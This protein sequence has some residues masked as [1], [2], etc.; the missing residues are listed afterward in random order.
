MKQSEIK[1]FDSEEKF[2]TMA[3]FS[4]DWEKWLLPDGSYEYISPSCERITGY[5]PEEFATDPDLLLKITHP[6][7]RQM[8]TEHQSQHLCSE[9]EKAELE[10]RIISKSGQVRWI[11]HK[12]SSV[13]KQDGT[14]IGRRISNR[15]ITDKHEAEIIL[16]RERN[17]FLHGPVVTFTWQNSENWPVE[18]V[19][20]NVFGVL[21]YSTKEF[22]EGSILYASLI[23]PDDLDRV[24]SEVTIHSNDNS[25]SFV[26]EPYRLVTCSGNTIWVIDTTTIIKDDQGNITHYIGYLV[27]I[28]EQKRQEQIV[29]KSAMQQEQLKRF[30]SLKTMAGAIAHRFNN[31]MM[32]VQ[33]NLD[34]MTYTLL[35]DSDEYKMASNAAEA[36]KGASQ[37]GSMMLS[38]VGQR[39]LQLREISLFNLVRECGTAIKSLSHSSISL[40]IIPPA[41]EL[42]CSMDQ[43]QIQEVIENILTN[44]L[45]SMENITGTIVIS[46]GTEYCTTDSFPIA[47]QAEDTK[48][49]MYAFCQIKDTGQGINPKNLPRI[50]EPFYTT[51]FVGR[52]L[53]LALTVGVM[54]KHSGAVTAASILTKGTTV[55]VLLPVI[56]SSQQTVPSSQGVQNENVQLSGDILLVDDDAIILTI[57]K[58]LLEQLGF[59]VHTAKNGQEAVNKVRK[60]DVDFCAAVMDISMPIM[61]G[62]EAKE[63]IRTIDP[64]MPILLITGYSEN[65]FPLPEEQENRLDCFLRKPFQLVDLQ[66]S[67]EE[68]LF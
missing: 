27:D 49:G 12:C 28:S 16:Q 47:F 59:T 53:G 62:L 22:I 68:L 4:Y 37:V 63:I 38:Y 51:R 30:E 50:F 52:G 18:Q 54:R 58:I 29:L 65:D 10:F 31:A 44:A 32:A 11:W 46:F 24:T 6:D 41:Q 8:M 45:E 3:D 1:L 64:A 56:S 19:S 2:R 42:Y 21:G 7:D 57:C 35:K 55:K 66:K 9:T 15:D 67:L 14:W 48:D 61:D 36:A 25:K 5:T 34:L 39:P 20:G 40:K 43:Q 33:G 17:M 23:H 60:K 13:F 26:H